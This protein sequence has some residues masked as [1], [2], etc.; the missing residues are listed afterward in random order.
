M[1]KQ[2]DNFSPGTPLYRQVEERIL[3][4]IRATPNL[5]RR[6]LSDHHLASR[7]G[8]SRITVRK[9]ISRLVDLGVLY[10]VQGVGTFARPQKLSERL[11]MKSFLDPWASDAGRLDVR[12]HAFDRVHADARLA[13]LLEVQE[14][15]ELVHIERLRT[16]NEAPVA[17]DDRYL[18]VR[19]ARLLSRQDIVT[20]SLVDYLRE[21]AG[22]R[23]SH[24][25]MEIEARSATKS[26]SEKL[27]LGRR[28]PVLVRQVRFF[29]S[30]DRPVL[31]GTSVYRAGSVTYKVDISA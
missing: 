2:A 1:N 5:G 20:L 7:F 24:G 11:T 26:E 4:M 12:I 21:R 8:V 6:D 31:I 28:E 22:V 29:D 17:V 15:E 25:T 13:K 3:E 27:E 18:R 23:V 14:G 30:D 10:R 16:H 9:A 19:D